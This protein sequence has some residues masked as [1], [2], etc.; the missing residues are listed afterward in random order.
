M[1]Y[2][3][4]VYVQVSAAILTSGHAL[5]STPIAPYLYI[6][7]A[8]SSGL[9]L[10][11]SL[12][13]RTV[14]FES[15]ILIFALLA[16]IIFIGTSLVNGDSV[17]ALK[18]IL[19]FVS[20]LITSIC[21]EFKTIGRAVH[22]IVLL[23]AVISLLTYVLNNTYDIILTSAGF[24]NVHGVEYR[25]SL[26]N[27]VYPNFLKFRNAGVF[28][29]PG[30]YANWL[31]IVL[32]LKKYKIVESSIVPF[33]VIIV[34]MVTTFSLAGFFYL[35]L[36]LIMHIKNVSYKSVA[37]LLI[38]LAAFIGFYEVVILSIDERFAI[39]N[40]ST[41]VR[42]DSIGALIMLASDNVMT[43]VGWE[44]VIANF[45]DEGIGTLAGTPF[46][47]AASFGILSL[48]IFYPL[49]DGLIFRNFNLLLLVALSVFLMKENHLFFSMFYLMIFY[50]FNLSKT[51]RYDV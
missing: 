40:V 37:L 30:L 33:I 4:L 44:A 13:F 21:I 11:Y 9:L 28:W 32:L 10:G 50:S 39:D 23:I 2:A 6:I 17:A 29:E 19:L 16:M 31:F 14:K 51:V 3:L 48:L 42:L 35:F 20:C 45:S 15:R 24:T 8:S 36:V 25:G 49:V 22:N 46:V 41:N 18:L 5:L 34:A 1:I 27:Y 43:G 7:F 12:L 26:L 38:S 47:F